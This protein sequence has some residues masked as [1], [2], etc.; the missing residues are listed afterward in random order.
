MFSG[1]F[2]GSKF[3]PYIWWFFLVDTYD[4]K[5]PVVFTK[6]FLCYLDTGAQVPP[7]VIRCVQEI[8]SR[9]LSVQGIYRVSGAKQRI[10]RLS[11]AFENG[12]DLV[13]LTNIP[14]NVIADVLKN[15]M[16]QLPEPL[17]TFRYFFLL[18]T[19]ENGK[20]VQ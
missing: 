11:Q 17:L 10:D 16:R 20:I 1:H 8:N 6:F 18:Y 14:P 4:Y 13:D 15:Y 19:I 12:P 3:L 9:G 5:K 7:I 2:W